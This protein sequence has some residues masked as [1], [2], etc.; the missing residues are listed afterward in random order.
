MMVGY[1]P[2]GDNGEGA[3]T[4][5]PANWRFIWADPTVS[6]IDDAAYLIEQSYIRIEELKRRY[7]KSKIR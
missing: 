3:V 2:D 4:L 5:N 7:P 6:N 1:D